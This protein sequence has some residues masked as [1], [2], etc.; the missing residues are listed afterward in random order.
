MNPVNAPMLQEVCKVQHVSLLAIM[1]ITLKLLPLN[2]TLSFWEK[3]DT[4]H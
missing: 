3:E 2:T 1:V 4:Q